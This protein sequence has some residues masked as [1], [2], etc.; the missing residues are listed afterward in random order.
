MIGTAFEIQK[1]TCECNGIPTITM[2]EN[3]MT[4]GE[5]IH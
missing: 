4:R 2:H 1:G 3:R 5:G